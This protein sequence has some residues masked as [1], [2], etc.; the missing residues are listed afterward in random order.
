M[1]AVYGPY[2]SG[3]K[4]G[5]F[6]VIHYENG[7][8]R[9]QSYPRYLMEQ[10]LGRKLES[11]EHVDH[12]NEDF[13][14]NRIDNLQILTQDENLSK[15]KRPTSWKN[16]ICPICGSN[17]Y[18]EYKRYKTNQLLYKGRGPFCSKRC[19]GKAGRKS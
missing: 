14:D 1:I 17:F 8:G 18:R 19:A 6:F 4:P 12:R 7:V 5:R 3:S 10:H 15:S 9:T 13:R 11:W 16:F 2:E